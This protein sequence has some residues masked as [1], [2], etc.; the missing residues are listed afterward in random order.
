[1]VCACRGLEGET[2]IVYILIGMDLVQSITLNI[3]EHMTSMPAVQIRA[4]T[5]PV[6]S[7]TFSISG[8]DA[9]YDTECFYSIAR[10]MLFASSVS[11][12]G[13]ASTMILAAR[14]WRGGRGVSK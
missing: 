3:A 4:A 6:A 12:Q 14:S 7:F 8:T 10:N 9:S 11:C 2:Q 1:M 5:I 13:M